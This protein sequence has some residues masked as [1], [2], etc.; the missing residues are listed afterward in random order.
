MS[1][2]Q[3]FIPVWQDK[4]TIHS[5]QV[6]VSNNATLVV[7]CQ[8]MQESAWNHAE[9]LE[10]GFSHLNRKNFIWVLC[11]QLVKMYSYPKW[12]DTIKVHTWPTAKD[13][14]F[15]YRDFRIS[16]SA[17]SIIGEATTTWFV[18][19][20]AS[21][22][23]Q[24]T[25]SYFHVD[26]PED[27]EPVFPGKLQ[28]LHPAS[29]TA[30]TRSVRVTYGDLDI[31]GHVN[32]VRYIDW[33]LNGLPFDYLKTHELKEM[34]INYLVEASYDDEILVSSEK[35]KDCHFFHSLIRNGD[36]TELCRAR[37]VWERKST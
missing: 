30:N 37:T 21:R 29:S 27:V 19:D 13:K 10:L 7:L 1:I 28:K 5:Y 4:Y 14:L 6:D 22:K 8:L 23:P 25:D 18:I 11:R 15:C 2:P 33:I 24:K 36:I 20:L 34:E 12:G 32:N 16:G 9:H 35:K 26:L 31:N 17:D 3:N